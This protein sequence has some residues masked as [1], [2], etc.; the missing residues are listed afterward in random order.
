MSDDFRELLG[1]FEK[2]LLEDM[3]SVDFGFLLKDL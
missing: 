1:N 2:I 3:K